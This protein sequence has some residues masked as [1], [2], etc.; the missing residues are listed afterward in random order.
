MK[1]KKHHKLIPT[2][3]FLYL[4]GR[5]LNP[6][7]VTETMGVEP[8]DQRRRGEPLNPDKPDGKRASTGVWEVCIEGRQ[9]PD[10]LLK[11]FTEM[12]KPFRKALA[13][14]RSWK[15]VSKTQSD[16]TI[17]IEPPED[18]AI[19]KI[20]LRA[21]DLEFWGS[22]GFDIH[23]NSWMPGWWKFDRSKPGR[24]RKTPKKKTRK[25]D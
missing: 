24:K 11:K 2:R 25:V 14:V 21:K 10:Q 18:Y 8:Y 3:I 16:V 9:R 5:N 7:K 6:D 15:S 20:R 17:W 23:I 1:R 12:A 22:L 19:N 13:A 4:V